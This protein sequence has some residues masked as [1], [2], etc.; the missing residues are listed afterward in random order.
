MFLQALSLL[1]IGG[2]AVAEVEMTATEDGT[3]VGLSFDSDLDMNAVLGL[4]ALVLHASIED[5]QKR[6][7]LYPTWEGLLEPL[8]GAMIEANNRLAEEDGFHRA[9]SSDGGL[10]Q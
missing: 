6:Q 4:M 5:A 8:M 1:V 2:A 7:Q 9:V 10:V 3:E